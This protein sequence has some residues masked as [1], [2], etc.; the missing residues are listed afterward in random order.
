MLSVQWDI[1]EAVKRLTAIRD[2]L[3]DL[4]P[5]WRTALIYLRRATKEQFA[6]LG[7]R[8]GDGWAPLTPAY[9]RR[10]AQIFPGKPILRATDAMFNSL[11][12]QTENSVVE[13][14]ALEFTYGTRTPYARYHQHGTPRMAQR[15]ILKVTAEDRRQIRRITNAY[16]CGKQITGLEN[17]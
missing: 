6:T 1:A 2:R 11:I 16:I 13:F 7:A 9:G 12:G 17:L 4:R 15:R 10:K 5:A 8:S 14:D 3:D